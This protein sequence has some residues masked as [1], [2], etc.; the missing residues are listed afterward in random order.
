MHD[1]SL[2][3]GKLFAENYGENNL[4][5]VDIGGRDVNGSLR[6]FFEEKGMKY[7]CVDMETHQSVDIVINPGDKLPF[8][9]QSIDL[10]VSTSCFEHDPCFWMTFKEM[11]RIIKMNGY[12]YINAPSNGVYHRYPGD[13]WRFYSDAGQALAY[14]SGVQISN[15]IVFPVKVIE[16]FHIIPLNDI[17]MDF[18]C[19]WQRTEIKEKEITISDEINNKIGRLEQALLN[20]GLKTIKKIN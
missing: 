16:T 7:I 14:W 13:N 5:V 19:I 8:E 17:W 6:S 1:T 10:I 15:E 20:N 11:S 9:N 4:I 18:I 3:S 12:I 2:I